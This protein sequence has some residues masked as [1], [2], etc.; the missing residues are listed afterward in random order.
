MCNIWQVTKHQSFCL[1]GKY[2][3]KNLEEIA[4]QE[5]KKPFDWL[6]DN[7]CLN[8]GI[9]DLFIAELL[10][11]GKHLPTIKISESSLC[12]VCHSS[13]CETPITVFLLLRHATQN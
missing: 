1:R 2:E 3:G 6:L 13:C 5:N 9:D 4:L 12:K 7:A 11:K 10:I 8:E